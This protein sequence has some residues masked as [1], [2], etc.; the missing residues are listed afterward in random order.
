MVAAVHNSGQLGS[1]THTRNCK[2]TGIKSDRREQVTS[3][4][5]PVR[6]SGHLPPPSLSDVCLAFLQRRRRDLGWPP[7]LAASFLQ[8]RSAARAASDRRAANLGE[9]FQAAWQRRA[10]PAALQDSGGAQRQRGE[11]TVRSYRWW[12]S[13]FKCELLEDQLLPQSQLKGKETADVF[14]CLKP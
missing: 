9:Q 2:C 12:D 8:R 11:F 4:M 10:A 5:S 13:R 1:V 14:I 3:D 7:V 6:R